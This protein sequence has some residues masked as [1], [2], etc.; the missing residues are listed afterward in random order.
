MK[1]T[2]LMAFGITF[3]FSLS[4]FAQG[5]QCSNAL[6]TSAK[7]AA[8]DAECKKDASSLLNTFKGQM[9]TCENFRK[10]K[11]ECRLAK[12]GAKK[13]CR[14]D[15]RDEKKECKKKKGKAK[16]QCKKRVR[17]AK[18]ACKQDARKEKRACKDEAK[19]SAE[20][21]VCK[22]SRRL[23]RKAAGKAAK[24]AAKHFKGAAKVCTQEII[25]NL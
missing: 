19:H 23:T 14:N 3:L 24:C 5:E 25:S 13:E 17:Q 18:K 15:K 2:L 10:M 6:E 9:K 22:D 1:R 12:R 8:N 4:A 21:E 7:A 16:R 11:K 20:F